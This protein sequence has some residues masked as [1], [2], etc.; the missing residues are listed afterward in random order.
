M[1]RDVKIIIGED[2]ENHALLIRKNLQRVGV[3]NEIHHFFNGKEVLDYFYARLEESAG[4]IQGYVLLLDIRMPRM[5]GIEVLKIL[6]NHPV[7]R[8]IPVIMLTTTDNPE[9]I[10]LCHKLGC[11]SYIIKPVNYEKFI[12]VVS[13]LGTYLKIAKV[14]HPF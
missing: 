10:D 5:D 14:P 7:L 2:D 6:K 9:E 8:K 3:R 13:S 12:E 11:N 1:D 4:D